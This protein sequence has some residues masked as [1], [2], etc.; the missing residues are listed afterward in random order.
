MNCAHSFHVG[1]RLRWV[2]CW[3]RD[4]STFSAAL[5]PDQK[6]KR[7]E[8]RVVLLY[9][10]E[11]AFTNHV[12]TCKMERKQ[13]KKPFWVVGYGMHTRDYFAFANTI[14]ASDIVLATGMQ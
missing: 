9:R 4:T 10:E 7:V 6:R 14:L 3:N 8:L 13:K 12:G 5:H 2:L 11:V 1:Q